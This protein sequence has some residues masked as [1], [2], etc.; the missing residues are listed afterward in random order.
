V[1]AGATGRFGA[2]APP[3]GPERCVEV[4]QQVVELVSAGCSAVEQVSVSL[5]RG[6]T[7]D[8]VAAAGEL[9]RQIDEAQYA[10]GEGPCITAAREGVVVVVPDLADETRWP[11]FIRGM[12]EQRRVCS[13]ASLPIRVGENPIGSLNF[14]SSARGAFSELCRADAGSELAAT[15]ELAVTAVRSEKRAAEATAR[16]ARGEEFLAGLAHDL[17]SGMTVALS[18]NEFLET[19]RPLLDGE[20][21]QAL[22]LLADELGRER[23][24]LTELLD[25]ARADADATASPPAEPVPVV[26]ETVERHRRPVPVRV[27]PGATDVRVPLHPVRL[28]RIL[29]N[30]LDN[31]DRHADGATA[32]RVGRDGDRAWV[33]VEDAGPGVP[34]DQ[35]EQ[36]FTRF[37]RGRV[38][39]EQVGAHLGLALS[40]QHARRAGGDLLVHDRDGGGA[41]FLLVLPITEPRP[42]PPSPGPVASGGLAETAIDPDRDC[43]GDGAAGRSE[44][45]PET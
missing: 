5:A 42:A 28:R 14:A 24:L 27:D 35:R 8:T 21:R 41:R 22:D 11:R 2:A 31:A 7:L 45:A 29:A 32:V 26:Y 9:A 4:L 6:E 33:A 1:A 17:R 3:S 19:Q 38:S 40:R 16:A 37:G 43:V 39:E 23:W 20:G 30:L 12:A 18:A 44:A 36:I 13:M 10:A 25:L 15:A 34:G